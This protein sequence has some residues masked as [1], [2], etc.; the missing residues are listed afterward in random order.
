MQYLGSKSKIAKYL[1]PVMLP[2]R[3][4]NQIWL[5]PFVGG[6]NMI[7]KVEGRRIGNDIDSNL[8]AM[9][10]ALQNGWIPPKNLS[11]EEYYEIKNNQ[12]EFPPELIAFVSLGCSF[13]GK[14]WGGY[15]KNSVGRNY[16]LSCCNGLM[17]Q[18]ENIKGVRFISQDYNQLILSEECLIY[19][20]PPY[21]NTTSY[22]GVQFSHENFWQWCRDKKKEGHTVFVS[23]YDAPPD[24]ECIFEKEHYTILDKNKSK[25]R[26]ERLFTI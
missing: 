5:E 22:Y 17:I 11:R 1:L 2:Y 4:P 10:V 25:P 15:A 19:C 23:E 20:D 24:F 26:T 12:G 9:W 6:C 16:A 13:G 8:I 14:K 3:K 18:A 7:D 21:K